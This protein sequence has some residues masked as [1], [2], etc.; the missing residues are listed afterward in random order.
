MTSFSDGNQ[1]PDDG[2]VVVQIPLSG[3]PVFLVVAQ[4]GGWLGIHS[5]W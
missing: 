1:S 4:M 3:R 2:L 5:E